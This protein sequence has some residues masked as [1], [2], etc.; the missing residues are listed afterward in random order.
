MQVP[1][2]DHVYRVF[3]AL[4]HMGWQV[5]SLETQLTRTFVSLY[6]HQR[7]SLLSWLNLKLSLT[8]SC[9]LGGSV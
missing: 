5:C 1:F 4:A 2:C 6:L 9:E 8:L 3:T 7:S